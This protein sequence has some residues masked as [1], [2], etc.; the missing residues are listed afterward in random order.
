VS[1]VR[2]L[3]NQ[4]KLQY[5]YVFILGFSVGATTAWLCSD[6]GCDGVIG[7]Y[8][9]RI[10]D[11]LEVEPS[12]PV[13]LFFPTRERTFD[14]NQLIQNLSNKSCVQNYQFDGEHGFSNPFSTRYNPQS[15]K[16]TYQIMVNFMKSQL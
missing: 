7:F 12:S 8:G 16:D 1:E 3:V 14:V 5:A 11:H 2:Q 15:A 4:L 9:S 13:L 6:C 10:R